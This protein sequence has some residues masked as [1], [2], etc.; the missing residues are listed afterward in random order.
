MIYHLY[1]NQHPFKFQLTEAFTD[2]RYFINTTLSRF[3]Y[4]LTE[5]IMKVEWNSFVHKF[6][7]FSFYYKNSVS[8]CIRKCLLA[9]L[10]LCFTLGK[11]VHP[12]HTPLKCTCVVKRDVAFW[13]Y[14][15]RPAFL[16]PILFFSAVD[17]AV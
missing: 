17:P 8:N 3:R 2:V 5:T 13:T 10:T 9:T 16:L 15:T 14:Y 1:K 12:S 11:T 4:V 6:P 7:N